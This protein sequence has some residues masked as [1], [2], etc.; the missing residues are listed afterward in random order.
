[1]SVYIEYVYFMCACMLF[2][3]N[4]VY[5]CVC[6]QQLSRTF[7]TDDFS[8]L[9][10]MMLRIYVR[11]AS[12][13]SVSTADEQLTSV[14]SSEYSHLTEMIVRCA[15]RENWDLR[16]VRRCVQLVRQMLFEP[17]SELVRVAR[18]SALEFVDV[19]DESDPSHEL[20]WK[21]SEIG[22]LLLDTAI[23]KKR[24][25]ADEGLHDLLSPSDIGLFVTTSGECCSL[26][27]DYSRVID[28]K[29]LASVEITSQW[30]RRQGEA[31]IV[32]S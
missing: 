27:F 29:K 15:L 28:N 18:L 14:A 12:P 25:T 7:L 3:V 21:S 11:R 20:L 8:R 23:S 1:V 9:V 24:S 17:D 19:D 30:R 22:S 2:R 26:Y 31:S 13:Y 6:V 4:G 16:D 5:I 10:S 32:P